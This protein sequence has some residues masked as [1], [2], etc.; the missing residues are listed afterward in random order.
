MLTVYD[1]TGASVLRIGA[2]GAACEHLLPPILQAFHE[3]FPRVE[4]RVQSGP[5]PR[6]IERLLEADLDV[7]MLSLPVTE[8]K[9]RVF[10]IGR[11]ELVVITA[12]GHPFAARKR[13]E[14]AEM[15][16]QPTSPA[17]ELSVGQ[18]L[19]IAHHS[20]PLR[21]LRGLSFEELDQ[22]VGRGEDLGRGVPFG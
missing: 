17:R 10:E 12:P 16:G 11:D 22:G 21:G 7:A 1:A 9:L 15:A 4:L 5:S 19:A 13:V 14:L 2:G 3:E 8:P 18:R 20:R 6:S